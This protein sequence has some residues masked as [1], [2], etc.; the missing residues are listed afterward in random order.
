[1]GSKQQTWLQLLDNPTLTVL[2]HDFLR[3]QNEPFSVQ[4]DYSFNIPQL[5]LPN[6]ILKDKYITALS[7][8]ATLVYRLSGDD[9]IVL[10]IANNKVLRFTISPTWTFQELYNEIESYIDKLSK[11]DDISFDSISEIINII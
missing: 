8:W 4:N 7:T 11:F 5:D 3:P 10:Y 1:M 2:P 6:N 9:D